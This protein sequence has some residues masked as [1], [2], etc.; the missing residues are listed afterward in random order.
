LAGDENKPPRWPRR[1]W[2]L[3]RQDAE[4]AARKDQIAAEVAWYKRHARK[5]QEE[6]D[7]QRQEEADRV[8]A[9][10]DKVQA[11]RQAMVNQIEAAVG[12]A[13][14]KL[15]WPQTTARTLREFVCGNKGENIRGLAEDIP[16]NPS[17]QR[18][19]DWAEAMLPR[20]HATGRWPKTNKHALATSLG[21]WFAAKTKKQRKNATTAQQR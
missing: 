6:Q 12:A 13:V 11:E 5:L 16:R 20:V 9:E 18:L 3:L 17:N 19:V 8:K 15:M 14:A 21:K 7:R 1:N 2:E 4:Y 10:A